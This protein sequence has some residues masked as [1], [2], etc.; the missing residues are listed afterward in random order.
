MNTKELNIDLIMSEYECSFDEALEIQA[1][2]LNYM[3]DDL[4]RQANS[5][6]IDDDI[7]SVQ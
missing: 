3:G 2:I 7:L 1:D 6:I 5:F 4:Q